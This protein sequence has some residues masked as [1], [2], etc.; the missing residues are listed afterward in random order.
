MMLLNKLPGRK[1][2]SQAHLFWLDFK[3]DRKG[4]T[5][6]EYGL[7]AAGVALAIVILVF[8]TGS[9]LNK[10]FTTIQTWLDSAP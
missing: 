4:A 3:Q 10:L 5:A 7:I 2:A 8:S 9:S 6:V 1:L